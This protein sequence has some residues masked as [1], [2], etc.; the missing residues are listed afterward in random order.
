MAEKG[1]FL[2]RPKFKKKYIRQLLNEG[3]G[4]G[5]TVGRIIF[6]HG[7]ED[8]QIRMRI[9]GDGRTY[10]GIL[11]TLILKLPYKVTLTTALTARK[12]RDAASATGQHA[13]SLN[14]EPFAKCVVYYMPTSDNDNIRQY[15]VHH[16]SKTRP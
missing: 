1:S 11:G 16:C 4:R 10:A 15:R 9:L 12:N 8:R 14:K 2:R 3:A 7:S 5:A 13:N 6:I